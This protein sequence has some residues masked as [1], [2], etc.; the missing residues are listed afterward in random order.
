MKQLE[1]ITKDKLTVGKRYYLFDVMSM[2]LIDSVITKCE[3]GLYWLSQGF[4]ISNIDKYLIAEYTRD[5]LIEIANEIKARIMQLEYAR[6][7]IL[8]EVV[9]L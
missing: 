3:S 5:G 6:N 9:K 4:I 8:E 2:H 7:E 1:L